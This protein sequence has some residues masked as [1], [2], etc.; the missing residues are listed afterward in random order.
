[1]NVKDSDYVLK[2]KFNIKF[3]YLLLVVEIRRNFFNNVLD[4]VFVR[5]IGSIEW[6]CYYIGEILDRSNSKVV[7]VLCDGLV[8]VYVINIYF[9]CILIMF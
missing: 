4:L 6:F 8:S 5:Y 3:F 7:F 2:L 9:L 1:M